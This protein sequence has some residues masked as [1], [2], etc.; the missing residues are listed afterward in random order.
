M[1]DASNE[2]ISVQDVDGRLV[3]VNPAYE[4]LFRRSA[5]KAR[6]SDHRQDL[7]PESVAVWE[8]E[9][10]PALARGESWEGEI[11]ARDADGRRFPV[12]HKAGG[13]VDEHGRMR[14][15]FAMVHEI[16]DR[17]RAEDL[18]RSRAHALAERTKELNCLY[19]ISNLVDRPGL[20][21]DQMLQ[22][23]V[24]LI[25]PSHQFP[26]LTCARIRVGD[27][28]YRTEGY[29]DSP[30]KQC[31]PIA[32]ENTRLGTVEV[33]YRENPSDLPDGAFLPEEALL[34]DAIAE[35]LGKLLE[36]NR[37]EAALRESEKRYRSLFEQASDGVFLFDDSEVI[38]DA[39]PR[40]L[41]T[42][43]YE[44]EEVVGRKVLD[45]IHPEDLRTLP[46][47]IHRLLA[48]ESVRVERRLRRKDGGYVLYEQSV[49]RIEENVILS[50]YRDITERKRAEEA[51]RRSEENY[52][53]VVE[54]SSDGIVI[55]QFGFLAFVNTA[56]CALS[57]YAAQELLGTP[58]L[59]LV[60]PEDRGRV[61]RR[62]RPSKRTTPYPMRILDRHGAVRWLSNNSI[63]IAWQG[64][65][66]ALM[67]LTDVTDRKKDQDRIDALS[68]DLIKSQENE[69]WE[70]SR[71]LHDRVAQDLNAAK[72]S[73]DLLLQS[74]CGGL[75]ETRRML[76]DLSMTL[77]RAVSTVRDLSY[78]LRPPGLEDMG[79]LYIVQ[80]HCREFS[81][82]TGIRCDFHADGVT[83]LVV[84]DL[85]AI[86]LYRFV[87]EALNNV[88]NHSG[89]RRV[90]VR[91][92]V[93]HPHVELRIEDDGGGFDVEAARQDAAVRKRMG[94]FGIQERVRL[95]KGRFD[96][97]SRIG[98]GT[99]MTIEIPIEG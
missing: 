94:L 49:R 56:F 73:A 95:L 11:D 43:G 38:F 32:F 96:L 48:G 44:K 33:G 70:I 15:A 34:L 1:V 91:L 66:G 6:G 7:P 23:I 2:A 25:P 47:Q 75:S 8:G 35:R 92:S 99:R 62:F 58:F 17:R 86:S 74:A 89:A 87:C 77:K 78:N 54:N 60:H 65:P 29:V 50:L 72:L 31:C 68:R 97:E 22:R 36:R 63:P 14:F 39:N 26:G 85:V 57:G 76:H 61:R 4:R 27:A 13:I 79:L 45:L 5:A 67:F 52:R 19:A 37:A 40:I 55:V 9:V 90:G 59:D 30:W 88:R 98:H 12:W 64:R 42:L 80:D 18:L 84:G 53:L 81:E 51:L 24:E 10:V 28:E 93:A 21:Q 83:D 69:R 82:K 20:T 41:A 71:E 46:S 16:T 3:Y